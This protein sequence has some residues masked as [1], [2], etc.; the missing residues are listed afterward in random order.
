MMSKGV[1]TVLMLLLSCF[2]TAWFS[3]Q[4][5]PTAANSTHQELTYVSYINGASSDGQKEF[6]VAMGKKLDLDLETGASLI[7]QGWDKEVVSVRANMSGRDARDAKIQYDQTDSG[8]EI[9]SRYVG[10]RRNYST[11]L[12]LQIMVPSRFDIEID[13][14]GGEVSITKVEGAISGKTMGGELTLAELKGDLSLTTMGGDISLTDSVVDGE[15][16]TMGGD[17]T[18]QDVMGNV[19][20]STMGG[21]VVYKNVKKNASSPVQK[22]VKVTSMGGEIN[23]DDAP[24]GADVQT[25]GGNVH[26]RSASQ[27]VKAE[28]MGGDID[29]D[30]VDGWIQATTMGGNVTATM[31]GDPS[32]GKRDVDITSNG[33]DITLTVPDGLS[34]NFDI[35]LAYTRNRPGDYKIISDFN[36]KQEESK[37]WHENGGTPRKYIEGTGIVGSGANRIKIHTINGDVT[38]KKGTK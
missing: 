18:L 35:E 16:K 33:G 20:G 3:S 15:V 25:M 9:S 13:S 4:E 17:V 31:V 5:P 32:S 2:K 8:L 12:D 23:V 34:M 30:S 7:I 10:D 21:D 28:T 26:V 38:I 29:L 1:M 22:E 37:Q 11:D 24:F 27:F 36:I 14:M 6:Q 19:R